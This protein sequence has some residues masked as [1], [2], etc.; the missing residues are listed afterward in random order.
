MDF[1]W[2]AKYLVNE[3]LKSV[4]FVCLWSKGFINTATN[5]NTSCTSYHSNLANDYRRRRATAVKPVRSFVLYVAIDT[6]KIMIQFWPE[7]YL[8]AGLSCHSILLTGC[9]D[10]ISCSWFF[11][12]FLPLH[13]VCWLGKVVPNAPLRIFVQF[14]PF[15]CGLIIKTVKTVLFRENQV[16]KSMQK[17]SV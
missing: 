15:V 2:L 8:T 16:S 1:D 10:L 17:Q 6:H 4:T 7:S 11:V 13:Y 12:G 14:R 5:D 9:V 3:I